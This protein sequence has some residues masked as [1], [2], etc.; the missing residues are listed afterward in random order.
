LAQI[1]RAAFG[2][3]KHATMATLLSDCPPRI[4][5]TEVDFVDDGEISLG[6]MP[7]TTRARDLSRD[8]RIA[9]H[10]RTAD[11]PADDPAGWLGDDKIDA[12][13]VEV[14]PDQLRMDIDSASP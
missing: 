8:P 5:G 11:A 14:E 12:S 2:V 9:S 7:G 13:A 4:S 3:R 10:C 1:V 6:I